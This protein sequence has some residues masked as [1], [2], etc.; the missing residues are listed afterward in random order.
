MH[1]GF[2]EGKVC[3]AIVRRIEKRERAE[4]SNCRWP[5]REQHAAPVEMVCDIGGSS[6][7]LSTRALSR[8]RVMCGFK[9][10]RTHFRP[11]EARISPSIP[12]SEYV[13]LDMLLK[14]TEGMRG[15]E[16][17][18]AAAQGNAYAQ[19]ALA[20]FYENGSGGL[21]KDELRAAHLRQIASDALAMAMGPGSER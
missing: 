8:L 12:Q 15:K 20:S 2:N 13:Q 14:A 6:S 10:M 4:R 3:D 19:M 17:S 18:L 21:P 11:L 9:T 7:P 16:L 1:I 5:E